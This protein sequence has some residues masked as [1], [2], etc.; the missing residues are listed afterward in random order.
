MLA[1]STFSDLVNAKSAID[2]LKSTK[3]ALYKK[4]VNVIYLTRQLQF[5]F[6]YMGSLIMDEMPDNCR[7]MLQVDYVLEVYQQEVEELK[8]D[9]N[10]IDLKQMLAS[11]KQIGYANISKLVLGKNPS[12]LVGPRV[13]R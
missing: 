10:V 4:F 11:Y 9:D 2:E 7:P 3:P 13:T 1:T 12:V 6:Q 5:K 8:K